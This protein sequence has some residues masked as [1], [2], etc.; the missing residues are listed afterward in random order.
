M[1]LFYGRTIIIVVVIEDYVNRDLTSLITPINVKLFK[2][3]LS[4]SNYNKEES[5][6]LVEGFTSGFNIEYQGPWDRQDYSRNIPFQVGVGDKF[7]MWNKIMKEVKVG[8]Y[9]G[10][11]DQIPFKNF[12]QSPIGLVPKAGNKMRLI[13]HLS[14]DFKK[15]KSINHY[16]PHHL[17]TVKYNDIDCV[18]SDLLKLLSSQGNQEYSPTV[19]Y[20]GKTDLVSAFRILPLK[21]KCYQLLILKAR[22]PG[23]GKNPILH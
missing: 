15:Y 7:D 12:V 6:F 22:H 13:F 5:E 3:L 21:S 23:N 18:V 14:Y 4:E 9:A 11:Y 10:P 20:Y 17:C 16:T 1:P 8:R 2:Q 19:I